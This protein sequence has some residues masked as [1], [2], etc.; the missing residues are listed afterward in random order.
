MFTGKLGHAKATEIQE[1]I[2]EVMRNI[3]PIYT[4]P[5]GT[6][7]KLGMDFAPGNI[8]RYALRVGQRSL[9]TF[10]ESMI[11]RPV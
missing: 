5:V 9:G 4:A 6:I 3:E 10:L 2:G 1:A 7:I 11:E 8:K